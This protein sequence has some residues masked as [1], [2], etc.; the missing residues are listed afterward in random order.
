M[1]E[2]NPDPID[3]IAN[4]HAQHATLCDTLEEIADSLPDSIDEQQCASVI[5]TLNHE[6]PLH[7]KDEEEGLFPLLRKKAAND[8]ALK[9]HLEQL[10]WEHAADESAAQEIA[11]VLDHLSHGEKPNNPE[12]FGYML[13][14]FFE[15]YRRHLHWENTVLLPIARKSLSGPDLEFLNDVMAN[16]RFASFQSGAACNGNCKACKP[17]DF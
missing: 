8:P 5:D 9:G 7:H 13:R 12:M 15:S 3:L 10:S 11:E 6:L 16:N 4:V 2:K 14:A 17:K 1:H